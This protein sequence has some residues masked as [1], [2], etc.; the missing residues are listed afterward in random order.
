MSQINKEKTPAEKYASGRNPRMPVNT[1]A[2]SNNLCVDNFNFL[3][4]AGNEQHLKYPHDYI[5]IGDGYALLNTNKNIMGSDAKDVYTMKL[6]MKL[7]TRCNGVNY[8]DYQV[9][10]N[11]IKELYGI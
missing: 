10:K 1:I 5:K 7:D 2:S 3:R 6:D 4:Q 9:I 11:K 8:A